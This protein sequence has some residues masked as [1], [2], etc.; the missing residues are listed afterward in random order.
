MSETRVSARPRL[1]FSGFN[2]G[3]QDPRFHNTCEMANT[4]FDKSKEWEETALQIMKLSRNRLLVNL[5]FLEPAFVQLAPSHDAGIP[6]IA[7]DGR[8]LYYNSMHVCR[9]YRR[10]A[11]IPVRDYLHVVLHCLYRHMFVGK[12][13]RQPLWDLACDI[14]VENRISELDIRSLYCERQDEQI[15]FI[16]RLGEEV[17]RLTAEHIYSYFNGQDISDEEVYRLSEIFHADD[18]FL[19][20]AKA[21]GECSGESPD[22]RTGKDGDEEGEIAEDMTGPSEEGLP[23]EE[24]RDTEENSI[25]DI[26]E[27]TGEDGDRKALIPAE[28]ED[29]WREIADRIKV[30]MESDSDSWGAGY[31][32]LEQDLRELNREKYD[33]ARLLKRFAVLGENLEVNDDEFDYIFYT[34]GMEL[35]GNMPLVEPL[36]YREVRKIRD[37]VIAIDTSESVSGETV[38]TF[39]NKTWNILKENENFFTG[40]N[41]H[42]IQCGARVEEDVRITSEAELDEYLSSMVLKGFGGTDFRPVF[43][44]IDMLL[45]C[46]E[47]TNFRGLIYFTDGYGSFPV[48]PPEYDAAFVLLDQG[49]ELPEVPPWAV[50]II[51]TED[52]I[53]EM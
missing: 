2:R 3:R 26:N 19:W 12:K 53:R 30:D 5:R 6:G 10:A 41:I 15:R 47:F 44:H 21:Q 52:E 14:A 16:A 35:Y 50:K 22:D 11:E 29:A 24:G 13:V 31:G 28:L 33:Y 45:R 9:Q 25:A 51:L 20:Y 17:P 23:E 46:H 37:L 42:I 34:Y 48:N 38:Q 40:F 36:E 43:E 18:H 27:G 8:N 4:E 1:F 49:Y 7:T 32:N 39:V